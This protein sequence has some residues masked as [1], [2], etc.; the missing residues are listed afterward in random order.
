MKRIT[1]EVVRGRT[2]VFALTIYLSAMGCHDHHASSGSVQPARTFPASSEPDAKSKQS[3]L[4]RAIGCGG[5]PYYYN[6]SLKKW[7]YF[8]ARGRQK[9][10]PSQPP[11][12]G[13]EVILQR[14]D[15][16]A[17]GTARK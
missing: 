14:D 16:K 17:G 4:S 6:R 10:S 2:V 13:A 7:V 5:N 9:I 3:D 12:E 15:R 8:D 11:C 1:H